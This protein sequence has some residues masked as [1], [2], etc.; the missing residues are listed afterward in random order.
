M[1]RWSAAT[2]GLLTL[3]S[4]IAST[5]SAQEPKHGDHVVVEPPPGAYYD[6]RTAPPFYDG[7]SAYGAP[8]GYSGYGAPGY[9]APGYGGDAAQAALVLADSA[10]HLAAAARAVGFDGRMVRDAHDFAGQADHF[11]RLVNNSR[12]PRALERDFL[13]LARDYER[14]RANFDRYGFGRHGRHMEEDFD[15][16]RQ[17]FLYTAESLRASYA[18][19]GYDR[20]YYRSR[21]GRQ[22]YRGGYAPAP[23]A[24]FRFQIGF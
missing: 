21:S 7:R 22:V 17:A 12:D 13:A 2:A 23:R 24:G 4:G 20:R 10:E 3:T 1:N 16:V 18:H 15:E 5:A 14:L 9:G 6:A 8:R 11:A 19:P